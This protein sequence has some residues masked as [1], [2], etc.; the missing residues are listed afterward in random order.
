MAAMGLDAFRFS[1]SW[2]RLIPDGRGPVNTKGLEYYNNFINELIRNGIQ[3]HV[4]LVHFD[5]PQVLHDEYGGWLSRNVVKDFVEFADVCFREFGDRVSYWTTF[6]EIN[7]HVLGGYDQGINP[8]GRCSMRS[9]CPSGDSA[10]EP[11]VALHNML[12]SHSA[13]AKLYKEK[14]KATQNGTLGINIY[15]M[16]IE[17]YTNSTE[18]VIA[19]QRTLTFIIGW[20]LNPVFYGDYP[21]AMKESAKTRMPNFTKY[22]SEQIKGSCDFIGVNYYFAIATKKSSSTNMDIEDFFT[23]IGVDFIVSWG[24][25]AAEQYPVNPEGLKT[26]LEYLKQAYGNPP[27]YIQENGQKMRRNTTLYDTPRVEYLQAHIGSVLAEIRNGSN[28][29]GYFEWT[30]LDCLELMDGFQ[31]SFGLYYVDLDDNELTRYQKLS[32]HWYSNFLRGNSIKPNAISELR[33]NGY[34]SLRSI[35]SQ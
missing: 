28:I 7:V 1:I 21:D 13:V 2:S 11:Y 19:A 30:L 4:T 25:V 10:R 27:I 22:E 3:P 35:L 32:A 12:L 5:L 34:A 16:A 33:K 24:G 6:N 15:G 31:S 23:D 9:I 18:D 8:P 17:P 20:V 14:Y 26:I 29:M